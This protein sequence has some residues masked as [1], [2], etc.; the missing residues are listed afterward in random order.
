MSNQLPT[1]Y[2]QFIHLS[3]YSRW[4]DDK[5]RRETWSETIERYFNFF[6]EHL[7]EMCDY[8]LDKKTKDQIQTIIKN[9][10][11]QGNMAKM[12]FATWRKVNV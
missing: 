1:Q 4:L 11:Y 10:T 6:E 3:R 2:Q 7:E 8:K 9:N 5:G 12:K